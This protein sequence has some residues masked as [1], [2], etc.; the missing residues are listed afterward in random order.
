MVDSC[1]SWC[2]RSATMLPLCVILSQG[3]RDQVFLWNWEVKAIS[4]FTCSWWWEN[5]FVS[6]TVFD[7]FRFGWLVWISISGFEQPVLFLTKIVLSC[8]ICLSLDLIDL[9]DVDVSTDWRWWR[10]RCSKLTVTRLGQEVMNESQWGFLGSG[11]FH[12]YLYYYTFFISWLQTD[13]PIKIDHSILFPPKSCKCPMELQQQF[14]S[15]PSW[16]GSSYLNGASECVPYHGRARHGSVDVLKPVD[17][18]C[19]FSTAATLE[20]SIEFFSKKIRGWRKKGVDRRPVVCWCW[21]VGMLFFPKLQAPTVSPKRQKTED[22]EMFGA[23][24]KKTPVTF[25]GEVFASWSCQNARVSH[26]LGWFFSQKTSFGV[27]CLF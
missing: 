25:G 8:L 7:D 6:L 15:F 24:P 18:G 27:C 10:R 17:G 26:S 1:L 22:P 20:I 12:R 11:Q 4:V 23:V 3:T 21:D 9:F 16:S 19:H 14:H 2:R 13:L 5:C